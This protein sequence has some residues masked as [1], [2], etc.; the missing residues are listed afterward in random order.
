[1]TS[2][3]LFSFINLYGYFNLILK[4]NGNVKICA[5]PTF[6]NSFFTYIK[7]VNININLKEILVL[8]SQNLK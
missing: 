4:L 8:K 2:N 6:S 5:I 3:Q 1:M 7:E